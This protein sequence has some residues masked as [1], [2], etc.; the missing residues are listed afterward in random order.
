[1]R[2]QAWAASTEFG[3]SV[4]WDVGYGA[5]RASATDAGRVL[6]QETERRPGENYAQFL[7]RRERVEN[8]SRHAYWSAR[9]TIRYGEEVAKR[10]GDIH[11][12]RSNCIDSLIDVHNNEVGRALGMKLR[13][14]IEAAL[15]RK[16]VGINE[17][18]L[19]I[20][21]VRD[22]LKKNEL[23]ADW[24]D[25]KILELPGFS[26]SLP[27]SD[28]DEVRS[29]PNYRQLYIKFLKFQQ[30]APR[31]GFQQEF[32]GKLRD[33][34]LAELEK[35]QQAIDGLPQP[36]KELIA[37]T[38]A[39]KDAHWAQKEIE[40]RQA[41]ENGDRVKDFLGKVQDAQLAQQAKEERE[42][43]EARERFQES[44]KDFLEK[45]KNA[46]LAQQAKEEREAQEARERLPQPIKDFLEKAKNAQLAQQAKEEREAQEAREKL[47]QFLK[48]I[49]E[50]GKP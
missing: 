4:A 8:A 9:M 18:E 25:D 48:A 31:V 29:P 43:Q 49:G 35:E 32:H 5:L 7:D 6:S 33:A 45:A 39:K 46:Q 13:P 21:A 17:N 47:Q 20:S 19:I 36:I 16:D 50:R 26:P 11:E 22:A 24:Y 37:A 14:E 12:E 23:I 41:K 2:R 44:I 34:Q 42:A 30:N 27:L 28:G 3:P 15:A 1:M 40:A 38:K 10:I